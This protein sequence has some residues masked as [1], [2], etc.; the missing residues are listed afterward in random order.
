MKKLL[1]QT[2]LSNYDTRG[3]FILECDSGWQMV[4]G[5]VREMLKQNPD[6]VI[7][8]MGPLLSEGSVVT[9]P[10]QVNPDIPWGSR[11]HY[12]EHDIFP[13]ALATRYNFDVSSLSRRL[14]LSRHKTEV[15]VRY[16]AVY[17]NDPMHL[18]NFKAMFLLEGGYQPKFYVHSHFVDVPSCPKFPIDASLWLGQCEAALKADWNFWQCGSALSE[19]EAEARKLFRDGVVDA[20]M[21]KSSPW[22][23]GYSIEEIRSAPDLDGIRFDPNV[24]NRWREQGKTIIFVPNRI[25]GKGRSSDYTNCGKF[26]FDVLPRLHERRNDFVVLAGNP[27]QKFSNEE[28]TSECGHNGYVSL[29]PDSFTRDE[30]KVV[31]THVDIAL[32]LYDQDTYGGTVA[33]ECVEL[34]CLPLWL[35]NFEYSGII[36]DASELGFKVPVLAKSDFSDIVEVASN[37]IDHVKQNKG[38]KEWCNSMVPLLNVVRDRCS[39][40]STTT[41]AMRKMNLL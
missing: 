3:R 39:Y 20:V 25:G 11:V 23:D 1:I 4:M 19:F 12:V 31:A 36:R 7:H 14:G 29:V 41:H 32:G 18:R 34:G 26:M 28:L 37:L 35:N 24:F 9:T 33:R 38:T 15:T 5:R 27:S 16:D 22:D 30:F 8:V 6:L 2:Q 40:E 21:A 13:N 17:L 10:Y